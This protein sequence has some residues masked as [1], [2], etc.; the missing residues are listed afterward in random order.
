M[1]RT[2]ESVALI[3][4][5]FVSVPFS[6]FV[7]SLLLQLKGPADVESR[8]FIWGHALHSK[9]EFRKGKRGYVSYTEMQ[10]YSIFRRY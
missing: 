9:L 2:K 10:F 1:N 8:N 4:C 5:I 6:F 7:L 3:V